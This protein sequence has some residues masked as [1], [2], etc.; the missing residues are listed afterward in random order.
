[1]YLDC[2]KKIGHKFTGDDTQLSYNMVLC[3][4]YLFMVLRTTDSYIHDENTQIAIGGKAFVGIPY[5]NDEKQ[6]EIFK[7]VG[8]IKILEGVCVRAVTGI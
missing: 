3:R 6:R 2:L 4:N 5:A 7:K 1:M 8:L